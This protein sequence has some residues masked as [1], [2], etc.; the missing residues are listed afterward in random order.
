MSTVFA[1]QS[2]LYCFHICTLVNEV[3]NFFRVDM[4]SPIA[5]EDTL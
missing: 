2:L 1:M 4:M 5:E 3:P